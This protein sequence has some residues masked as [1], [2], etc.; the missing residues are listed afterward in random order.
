MRAGGTILAAMRALPRQTTRVQD[1]VADF[2]SLGVA[3]DRSLGLVDGQHPSVM[4]SPLTLLSLWRKNPHTR[5]ILLGFCNLQGSF[6][7]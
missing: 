5:L 7:T 4:S 2:V 6:F 1:M 3:F